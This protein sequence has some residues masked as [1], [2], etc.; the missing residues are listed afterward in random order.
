[1]PRN[2]T[3]GNLALAGY[4]DIFQSSVIPIKGECIVE[5]PL[6]ELHP[7]EFHPFQVNDDMSMYRLAGKIKRYGVL[8][9][10]LA[11]PRADGGYELLCGNRRKRACE[12][13]ERLTM[14]VIIREMD[15]E[16]AAAAMVDSNIEAREVILPSE[17]AWAYKVMMDALNHNGVKGE[18]QSY[19]IKEAQEGIK[20]SQLYRLM[21]LTELVLTLLDRVDAKK[22]AFNPAVE[23]SHLSQ[24]EQSADPIAAGVVREI[25]N[26]AL[27]GMT[28]AQIRDKLFAD[29]C[30][31]PREYEYLNKGKDITPKYN[32]ASRQIWRILNN[33][34]YTGT[35]IAGK[36][37][38]VR[39]GSKARIE[40]D[41]S[42]WTIIPDSHPPIVSKEDYARVQKILKPT[43]E[44][45]GQEQA[46]VFKEK[47]KM[48][49]R[50]YLLRGKIVCG[51]CGYAMVYSNPATQRVYRCMKTH[52]DKTAA[53][54]KMK[55]ASSEIDNVVMTIIRKQ[56]EVVLGSGDLTGFRKTGAGARSM[57]DCEKRINQL[58][59]QRQHCYEQ[60]L[61]GEIERDAFQ[62][63][64]AD[65]TAQ[66]DRLNNQFSL[67]KQAERDKEADKK[68]LSAAKGAL[69]EKATPRDVVD[70]LVDKVLVFP[71]N[72]VEIH[73]KFA[74]FAAGL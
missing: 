36:G 53:C 29:R 63:L 2:K 23:L 5:M 21:R 43:K 15:D 58:A 22:L 59:E 30:L 37:E 60:F 3:A 8:A 32:W 17:R 7:P 72:H 38:V 70:A 13:A 74:N 65:Y 47:R 24:K 51:T 71:G 28:T 69:S 48:N 41:R 62:S 56:A 54:H 31:A 64:K 10:G 73:W 25:F 44:D 14:P 49:P 35:Y 39:V 50:D 66:I 26:M 18:S 61:N 19:E 68:A 16:L 67:L 20:K 34:Q 4:D 57:G 46:A 42:E 33:E 45:S 9:P 40:K 12:L 1:M 27:G 11:R 6:E 55:V 52:A